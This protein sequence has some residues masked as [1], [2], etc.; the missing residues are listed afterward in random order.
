MNILLIY[1][2]LTGQASRAVELAAE[3][4]QEAGEQVTR[5]RIDFADPSVRPERP[6][7]L[8][9]VKYWSD[10]A[11]QG[12]LYPLSFDPPGALAANYDLVLIFSNT[13][14]HHPSTPVRS[15]LALDEMKSALKDT[16]FAIYV[17]CRRIWEKNAAIVREEA[18]AAGG[19]F[20][21]ARHFQHHGGPI[22]SLLTTVT[23]MLSSREKA[24]WPLPS[25][26]LSDR[27]ASEIK[28]FTREILAKAQQFKPVA[29]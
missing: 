20:M 27:A 6:F 9:D 5:C 8:K 13:W 11:A 7:S 2:S 23:Y 10:S 24:L 15:L 25:F 4:L 3:A 26:G 19:F 16:P 28:P 12:K 21:G 18:E 22:G 17:V 14:Q 1:Y 29:S